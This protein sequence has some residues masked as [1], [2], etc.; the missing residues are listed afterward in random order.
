MH[1]VSAVMKAE[2]CTFD[3]VI[4]SSIQGGNNQ[5]ICGALGTA[6]SYQC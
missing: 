4:F 1:C 3:L 6:L 5:G 2:M